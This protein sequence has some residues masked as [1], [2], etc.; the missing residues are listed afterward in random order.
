MHTGTVA[1]VEGNLQRYFES[2]AIGSEQPLPLY[3]LLRGLVLQGKLENL[4]RSLETECFLSIV[5]GW[6]FPRTLLARAVGRC[7]AE[8]KVTR[9]R[10]AMIRAYL[11]RNDGMEVTVG[12]DRGNTS[13]GYRLG[14]LL[15][16][17]ERVQDAAQNNPNKTIVDRY[18]GAASTRPATVFPRLVALAQ[19]HLAKL[20]GGLAA[21]YQAELG[22]V[23]S[24]LAGLPAT[25]SLNEQG[26]F[27]IGYYHQRQDFYRKREG[28]PGNGQT[29]AAE[30]AQA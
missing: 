20:T 2:I 7:R 22:E 4:P 9:D 14:R 13:A 24:G 21:F 19:H 5:F 8:Q 25:L 3:L 17:L 27:G 10:A 29:A 28:E 12:L 26:L 11:I 23:I 15:A 18:Y 6:R 30:G 1:Q 16:V